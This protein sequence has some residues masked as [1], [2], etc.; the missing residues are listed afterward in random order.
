[1]DA[2][3]QVPRRAGDTVTVDGWQIEVLEVAG[4]VAG[5]VAF[6]RTQQPQDSDSAE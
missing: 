1:M 6:R 4:H 2:L 5:R 3:G